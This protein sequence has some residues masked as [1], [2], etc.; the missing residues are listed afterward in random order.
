MIIPIVDENDEIIGYKEREDRTPNEIVRLT[1]VWV[2][3]E[4]GNIL[5]QQRGLNR[6]SNPGIWGPSAAGHVEEGETYDFNAYKELEEETG[7]KDIKLT[8]SKK[9]FGETNTGKRF[10]QLYLGQVNS[11]Y[12]LVP[13]ESEVEKLKWFSKEELLDTY[14]K[15]P[16]M[17][18]GSMKDFIELLVK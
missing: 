16:E 18:V 1:A 12:H 5:L 2:T 4:N 10:V 3:D 13:Q 8:K 11:S 14:N 15:N 6:K 9:F 17:F 7:I